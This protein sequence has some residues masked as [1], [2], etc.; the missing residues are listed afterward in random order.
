MLGMSRRA[1]EMP[2]RCGMNP[3][4]PYDADDDRGELPPLP[5]P[6]P[7]ERPVMGPSPEDRRRGEDRRLAPPSLAAPLGGRVGGGSYTSA[8]ED[9]AS[10]EDLHHAGWSS[11]DAQRRED[12]RFTWEL[13]ASLTSGMLANPARSHASV[14]DA[15]GLFDQFLQEMHAYAKI[16]SE[17]DLLGSE[18]TRR[19]AHEEYFHQPSGNGTTAPSGR[20]ARAAAPLPDQVAPP[21]APSKPKPEPTQPRPM[22]D[23]RPIPPGS[24]GPYSP[25]SMGGSPPPEADGEQAA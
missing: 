10:H 3:A 20:T 17:F 14:K 1:G 25:G 19:R 22:G 6:R 24:R 2:M 23:Y 13:A 11:A 9:E 4:D 12:E 7:G 18:S 15:M 16:A 21:T 8:S 5:I